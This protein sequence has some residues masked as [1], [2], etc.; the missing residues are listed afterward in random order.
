M[1]K[2]DEIE[3][4]GKLREEGNISQEEYEREKEKI[5]N[6]APP[7][8]KNV[9]GDLGMDPKSFALLLHLSSLIFGIFGPLV[10][11]LIGK[12]KDSFVDAHGKTAVNFHISM[13]IYYVASGILSLI[14]IGIF[15]LFALL[16]M[17]LVF[18]IIAA[19]KANNGEHY[20]YP[21]TIQFIK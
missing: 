4:L 9:N 7:A 8:A 12:E 17:Q 16:I 18:T 19:V 5:L 1:S 10:M 11:W 15:M 2:Y 20:N 21:L 13:I 3:R 14:F 6:A